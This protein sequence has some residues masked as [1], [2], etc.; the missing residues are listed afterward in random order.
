MGLF[1]RKNKIDNASAEVLIADKD[2]LAA[3]LNGDTIS[4]EQA[5]SI[6]SV[7]SAVDTIAGKISTIPIKFYQEK[8][9]EDGKKAVVE[10]EDNRCRLLNDD[11][12]D[13]LTG[14]QFKKA[15]VIDYLLEKGG[16]AFIKS[17]G[18]DVKSIHYVDAQEVSILKNED[19]IFKKYDIKVKNK[20]YKNYQFI[21]ILK[22]TKDGAIGQSLREEI[23]KSLQTAYQN[24]LMQL[25]S[26][27]KGG[28]KRG[29]LKTEKTLSKEVLE[30]LKK[31]WAELYS[32]DGIN[33]IVLPQGAEFQ[34]S[35][36]STYEQNVNNTRKI[37][38]DEI[39]EIFHLVGTETEIFANA[40]QPILK[41]IE[42]S[43]NRD[44]MLEKEK[45]QKFFFA[46][47]TKA[48]SMG[49]M[50]TRYE[51]YQIGIKN[52]ILTPNECRYLENLD[53]IEG[54]DVINFGLSSALYNPKTKLFYVP[55]TKEKTSLDGDN[56]GNEVAEE[57]ENEE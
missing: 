53:G 56:S 49:D 17:V 15:L 46:F 16:Y 29:F 41:E 50:K 25:S 11:T 44:L 23:S 48:M 38:N 26:A 8:T 27:K 24:L 22:S 57:N 2:L 7:A 13:T 51:A 21:K 52:S 20:V 32:N 19:P 6:P 30:D 33:S 36:D 14:V 35:N 47:D 4:R 40:I 54:L 28:K 31:K 18:N 43:I 1:N 37:L 39:K 12:Q 42:C 5:L 34:E 45:E 10:V 9:N 55:N 3:L